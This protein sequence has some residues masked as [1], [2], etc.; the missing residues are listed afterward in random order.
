MKIEITYTKKQGVQIEMLDVPKRMDEIE[1][2]SI[3]EE[4]IQELQSMQLS[5]MPNNDHV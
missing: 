3:I 1:L 2:A 4:A 5:L